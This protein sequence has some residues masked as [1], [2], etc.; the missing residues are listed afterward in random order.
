MVLFRGIELNNKN[1]FI[2]IGGVNVIESEEMALNTAE[3]FTESCKNIIY[4]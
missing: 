3:I 4:L 1:P 2:L